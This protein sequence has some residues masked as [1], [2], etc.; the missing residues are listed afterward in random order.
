MEN[1]NDGI[2]TQGLNPAM[3]KVLGLLALSLGLASCH[4]FG[5]EKSQL[6]PPLPQDPL[7]QVYFNHS[8]ASEYQEPYRRISRSGDDLEALVVDAIES[9]QSSI[10]V[11]VQEIR[12]PRVAQALIAQH[13]AGLEV[14]II[15]EDT[16][17]QSLP[18]LMGAQDASSEEDDREANKVKDL[19]A[20]VDR[21]QDGEAS[22]Q[23]LLERDAI[24]M[25]RQDP[26]VPLIDDRADGSKGSGLMHHKFLIIDDRIVITGSANLTPSGVHG[27]ILAPETRGNANHLLQLDSP[28]LAQIFRE[29]FDLMWGDG[30]GAKPD[31]RFGLQKP[32]R[33][34]QSVP[35]GE[36]IVTV[37][38]SPHSPKAPWEE[39][40]NGLIAQ[41][42]AT[43]TQ[44]ANLALFVFSEQG[45]ADALQDAAQ[46]GAK[47]QLLIDPSFAF[48]DYSEGLDLLGVTL[49][50]RNCKVEANNAPWAS[51]VTTVGIPNLPIGDKL[52]H[53]FAVL[54]QQ[55]V[56]T[57]SHNWSAS[58]NHKNDETLLVFT[59]AIVAAHFQREF[60]RLYETASLGLPT[61]LQETIAERQKQ[62][63]I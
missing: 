25:L 38:F 48:R 33:S 10:A 62:C 35:L 5:G 19:L 31:S 6:L 37:N 51:P 9:A 1:D 36:T 21:N 40:T 41:T 52:H 29:E 50:G 3:G 11:A 2:R 54:D 57:G 26:P 18:E 34:P 56:I 14:Q 15:I 24:Y 43:T 30:P 22:T 44:E 58:A 42:L 60:N 17:N 12:L 8:Q 53:K 46:Q 49:P 23:E 45:L 32:Q 59:N 27:D 39:S 20:L 63:G 7:I 4:F 28:A 61:T 55:T 13:R 16:Y 47:V